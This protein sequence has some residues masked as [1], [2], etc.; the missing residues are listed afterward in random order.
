MELYCHRGW[1]LTKQLYNSDKNEMQKFE[2]FVNRL[3]NIRNGAFLYHHTQICVG[4]CGK[5]KIKL[6]KI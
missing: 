3:E 2:S 5:K 1:M 6:N 4:T